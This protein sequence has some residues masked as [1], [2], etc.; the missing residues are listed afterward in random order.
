VSYSQGNTVVPYSSLPDFVSNTKK[1]SGGTPV[2]EVLTLGLETCIACIV[3]A[4]LWAMLTD[5]PIE[6]EWE[7]PESSAGSAD[8]GEV[9]GLPAS[10]VIDGRAF[11][12]THARYV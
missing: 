12:P 1:Y 11:C 7:S 5:D 9:C 4:F 3:I 6:C 8:G 2:K 10:T